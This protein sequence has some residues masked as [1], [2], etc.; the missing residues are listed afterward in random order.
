MVT[1]QHEGMD[2]VTFKALKCIL[3][4]FCI[5]L[6]IGAQHSWGNMSTYIASYYRSLG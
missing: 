5:L 6:I 1:L 4:A 3:G 2:K